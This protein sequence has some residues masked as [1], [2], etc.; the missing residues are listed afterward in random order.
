[1]VVVQLEFVERAGGPVVARSVTYVGFVG[2]LTGVR[3]GYGLA[4]ANC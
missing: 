3:Y 1:L 2:I 4:V